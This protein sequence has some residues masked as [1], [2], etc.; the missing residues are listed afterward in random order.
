MAKDIN[1]DV[2]VTG[3][4][5]LRTQLKAA[6]EDVVALQ[7]ADILDSGAIANATKRAGELRD[8]LNDANEQIKIM[9]GGTDF[10]KV[11]SGLSLIGDQLSNLDFE[12]AAN[13]AKGLTSV[14]K[15]MNPASVA[16]GFNDLAST[17]G[18]LSKAFIQ[19][20]LK[21]LANPL[22][23][24]VA[25]IVAVVA[26]IVM[27]KDK[28]KI[29]EQ[30]FDLVM[31]PI[32]A[33]I[34]GLKDLTDWLGL[35]SFAEEEAAQKS[36][37]AAEKRI[38]ANQKAT[39]SMDKEFGRQI[40]LAKANGEDTTKLETEQ[41]AARQTSAGKNIETLNA[42]IAAQRKLLNDE[43][44][45]EQA[46]RNKKINELRKT[47]DAEVEINKDSAS[48]VAVI[49]ATARKKEEDENQKAN[50]KANENAKKSAQQ[51]REYARQRLEIVRL[52]KDMQLAAMDEGV[53]KE[54][55]M[56]NEKYTRLIADTMSNEKLLASEKTALKIAYEEQNKADNAKAIETAKKTLEDARLQRLA[57]QKKEQEDLAA[58]QQKLRDFK[59]TYD[60][61]I[62]EKT[63]TEEEK[64][65]ATVD[66][67]FEEQ[68]ANEQKRYFG[69]ISVMNLTDA[70]KFRLKAEHFARMKK[71][72]EMHGAEVTEVT[73]RSAGEQIA[74]EIDK[75]TQ[76][77]DKAMVGINAINSFLQQGDT[78]RLN[79]IKS[80]HDAE[81][82]SLQ[83][84]QDKEL[85]ASNLSETQKKNI[86]AKYAKL[87]YEADLKAFKE[88]ETIKKREFARDKAL[89]MVGVVID[90]AKAV[91]GSIA[92]SPLTFGMPWAAIN[93]GVG[94]LQLATIASTSYQGEA[95]PSAPAIG[96]AGGGGGSSEP[97]TPALSLSGTQNQLNTVGP[98]GAVQ[99]QTP[100]ITVTAIVS[101]TE[102]T[103]TQGR[104]ARIQN[105]AEL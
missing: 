66:K 51:A 96:G 100:N 31:I 12:G 27:L 64:K 84:K 75:Y 28:V 13:T 21:L 32:K 82:S 23:L 43:T 58:H 11:S 89:K 38:A 72:E 60:D 76:I 80:T 83:A 48:Q 35:T 36:L 26:A 104:V 97:A 74:A 33:L 56:N 54:V 63:A 90:T 9:S 77:A 29:M 79:D 20:G 92:A 8:K 101:E 95:G 7:S 86:N 6:R 93:A 50:D 85:S 40:A 91:S 81:I 19:M 39:A 99:N 15:D 103:S 10:E 53:A 1:V 59:Q 2:K 30:A 98:N 71:L 78:N 45:Q 68:K 57:D 41:A 47:R 87:K 46:E 34:Q 42:Q 3:L 52:L 14:I 17:V 55:A 49:T 73:K 22:F 5:D 69:Q 24:L 67:S 62:F 94:L 105:S 25:I 16:K 61:F 70:E 65:I 4:G 44:T 18:Q 37:E 102:I 88:T